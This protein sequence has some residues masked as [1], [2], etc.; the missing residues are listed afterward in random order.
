MSK[1]WV[2]IRA[3][4]PG[5]MVAQGDVGFV[6]QVVAIILFLSPTHGMN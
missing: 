4:W 2:Q 3:F 6:W 5:A 1:R